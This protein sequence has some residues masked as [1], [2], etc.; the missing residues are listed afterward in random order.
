M[1]KILSLITA[2]ILIIS[3]FA[4]ITV[5]SASKYEEY[6]K[7][8]SI[9]VVNKQSS[10]QITPIKKANIKLTVNSK[11]PKLV[12][13]IKPGV[14][15]G[16]PLQDAYVEAGNIMGLALKK[17]K[18]FCNYPKHVDG[19]VVAQTKYS[20][21][22]FNDGGEFNVTCSY[23]FVGDIRSDS[24]SLKSI[25]PEAKI[26][27][28]NEGGYSI[29]SFKVDARKMYNQVGY[30]DV[31]NNVLMNLNSNSAGENVQELVK[32]KSKI[33]KIDIR[34]AQSEEIRGGAKVK[35]WFRFKY[36]E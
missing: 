27:I 2:T 16:R 18:Q 33:N 20:S 26:S 29:L 10:K 28:K 30:F 11:K 32:A 24:E 8:N 9:L 15:D 7:P 13:Q 5:N 25:I 12:S 17:F 1:T 35:C 4:M 36:A 31:C 6:Q 14:L 19:S 34:E 22:Y 23:R 21:S 3:T